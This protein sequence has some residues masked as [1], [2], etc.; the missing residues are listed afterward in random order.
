MA[1]PNTFTSPALP[2][3]P[4]QPV[5]PHTSTPAAGLFPPSLNNSNDTLTLGDDHSFEPKASA[6]TAPIVACRGRGTP[7]PNLVLSLPVR[8]WGGSWGWDRTWGAPTF[9]P[10][11]PSNRMPQLATPESPWQPRDRRDHGATSNAAPTVQPLV[12]LMLQP[13]VHPETFY[14]RGR[15]QSQLLQ[16]GDALG[17]KSGGNYQLLLISQAQKT[18]ADC[19]CRSSASPQPAHAQQ[20]WYP[21]H[22]QQV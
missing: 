21:T 19:R 2:T 15:D 12:P 3:P 8:N 5:V 11:Q 6:T 10:G 13:F 18:R 14:P 4:E 9:P 22:P 16:P 20:R 17:G 1:S 7:A